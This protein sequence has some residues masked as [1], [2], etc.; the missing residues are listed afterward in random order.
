MFL[1][2]HFLNESC[3]IFKYMLFILTCLKTVDNSKW[4][5][6]R[7]LWVINLDLVCVCFILLSSLGIFIENMPSFW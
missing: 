6:H 1:F 7:C 2:L 5:K 3:V 4:G